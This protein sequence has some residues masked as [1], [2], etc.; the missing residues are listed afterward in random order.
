MST[1]VEGE[2][3]RRSRRKEEGGRRKEEGGRV[4]YEKP[5]YGD[6][7]GLNWERG[8]LKGPKVEKREKRGPRFRGCGARSR[9]MV[10]RVYPSLLF[11]P[12]DDPTMQKAPLG[13]FPCLP[14]GGLLRSLS[15]LPFLCPWFCLFLLI[16]QAFFAFLKV[17]SSLSLSE[18]FQLLRE[19]NLESI[20][21][22]REK[23]ENKDLLN[24]S[25][26]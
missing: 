9:V 12:P 11:F 10:F 5:V 2:G 24:W 26:F 21:R 7:I 22:K 23:K 15:G 25:A 17:F 4:G 8:A 14:P 20:S 1:R 18:A 3:R 16:H 13:I 19:N 6:Q